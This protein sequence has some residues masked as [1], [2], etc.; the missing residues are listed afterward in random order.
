MGIVGRPRGSCG[1]QAGRMTRQCA[2]CLGSLPE[3]M[4]SD[5][6]FCSQSCRQAAHRFRRAVVPAAVPGGRDGSPRAQGDASRGS[7]RR[8]RFAYADPPY[9]GNAVRYYGDH[10]DFAGEVDHEALLEALDDGYPDGWALSTSSQALPSLL[11]MASRRPGRPLR[12]A[13]WFRGERPTASR[14]PLGAWEPVVVAGGRR[15]LS[16]VDR[17]TAR[18]ADL[19]SPPTSDGSES[20]A[21]CQTGPLLQVDVRASRSGAG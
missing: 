3:T 15:R 9:P 6:R 20:G 11:A 7:A 5:A 21:R 10:S 2:W 17:A 4:R 16:P 19:A 18:C 14:A 1:G 8:M 13:A 12:I